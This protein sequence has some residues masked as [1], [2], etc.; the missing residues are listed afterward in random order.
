MTKPTTL[1][2]WATS[3]TVELRGGTPN[4]VE[5]SSDLKSNGSLDGNLALNHFN[6][7][8]NSIYNWLS[9]IDTSFKTTDGNGVSIAVDD[10]LNIIYAV[11]TTTPAD[12]VFAIGYKASGSAASMNT[13]SSNT[14]SIGTTTIGGDIPIS[15]AVA[16]NI[17]VF[18][19]TNN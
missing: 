12:Y 17:L 11:D 6:F 14:L 9:F 16:S 8:L 1:P 15:G 13:I 18:N 5:P 2:E 10:A 3:D 19:L 7:L 4:K